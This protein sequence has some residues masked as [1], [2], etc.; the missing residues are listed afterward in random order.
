MFRR[1]KLNNLVTVALLSGMSSATSYAGDDLSEL[2]GPYLGQTP[3]GITP[4]PFA[5]GIVSTGNLEIEGVFAP[6][7][8][9]FYFTRQVPGSGVNT[10]VVKYE[11]GMWSESVVGPRTGEVFISTDGNTMYLGNKYRERTISGWS[12]EQSLGPLFDKFPVMRLTTSARG[13]YV[14]DE[15]DEIGTIRYSRVVDGKR[16][17]P[18]EFSKEINSGTFTGHPF[19]A[20]DESYIIWDSDREGGYGDSD[21]YISFRQDDGSWGS[22]INMGEDINTEYADAYGS[23][24]PDGKFFFFHTVHLDED[25]SND[26]ANI[27]WVDAQI[28]EDLRPNKK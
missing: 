12:E 14:F 18:K 3:P 26:F 17:K 8:K 22:A 4:E 9:E 28:I 25:R 24:T 10:H 7:M 27:F 5:P 13:T 16:E 21:L 20:S 11:H 15:R 2:T 23:V 19:I 1:L 6:G